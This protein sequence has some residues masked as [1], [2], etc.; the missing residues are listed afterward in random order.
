MTED[1][2]ESVLIHRADKINRLER[3]NANLRKAIA[4]LVKY[5]DKTFEYWDADE[6]HKVGKRLRAMAG[7]L[8]GYDATIDEAMKLC[9]VTP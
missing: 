4:T 2:I 3:E 9:E 1:Q 6:D 8:P 5:A 7:G